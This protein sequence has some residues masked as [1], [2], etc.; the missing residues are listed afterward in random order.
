[1][2]IDA[3][4]NDTVAAHNRTCCDII[5]SKSYLGAFSWYF[6]YLKDYNVWGIDEWI[7]FK[8]IYDKLSQD[9]IYP[10]V[11]IREI[12]GKNKIGIAFEVKGKL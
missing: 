8:L 3:F 9:R 2:N 6:L 11:L 1:M 4:I 12:N 7:L 5:I 10:S